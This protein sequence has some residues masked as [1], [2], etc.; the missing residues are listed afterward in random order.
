MLIDV[1]AILTA[2]SSLTGLILLLFLKRKRVNGLL[3]A[4]GGTVAVAAVYF[5]LVP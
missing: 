2:V 4:L 1:T 5:W 3:V